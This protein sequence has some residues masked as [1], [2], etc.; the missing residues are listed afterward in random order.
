MAI[1]EQELIEF[2]N[3]IDSAIIDYEHMGN[4]NIA[5]ALLSRIVLLMQ[6]DPQTGKDLV[7]Y[8][9]EKL[10]EIDQANPGQLL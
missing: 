7:R 10:D 4:H 3:R 1:N 5:G 9:W 2:V 8:V 6:T